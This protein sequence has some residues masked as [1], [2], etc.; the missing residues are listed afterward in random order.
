MARRLAVLEN[1]AAEQ[2]MARRLEE[3]RQ[4]EEVEPLS[5]EELAD[6]YQRE[7]RRWDMPPEPEEP[8]VEAFHKTASMQERVE[9][10][11][12]LLRGGELLDFVRQHRRR[13]PGAKT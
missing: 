4:A 13:H 3:E 6:R 2:N 8:E 9:C 10:Y 1:K 7:V 11:R 5:L 12:H